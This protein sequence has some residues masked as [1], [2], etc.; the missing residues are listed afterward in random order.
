MSSSWK[1][2]LAIFLPLAAVV[3]A[4]ILLRNPGE[5]GAG[6]ADLRLEVIT[7]H[8]ETIRREIG[9]AFSTWYYEKYGKTVYVNWRTPGGTSE[10]KRVLDSS[11]QA[12]EADGREG[13]GVDLF[14]GGGEYD[15][16]QQAALGR[17]VPLRVFQTKPE[18]FSPNIIPE[19][20]SGEIYYSPNR[21]WVGV[22]LSSFGIVY[23]TDSLA[24]LDLPEPTRWDDL[25]DPRY[26]QSL[27]L[28]D[29]TKSGS[30]AKAF[31]M[32]IQEK[33]HHHLNSGI[34]REEALELGWTEGLQLIQRIAANSRYFADSASKVP[35][36]VAQGNAAAGMC[37]DFYGR[38][39]SEAVKKD[40]GS[41]RLKFVTPIGGTS[42]SADPVAILKGAPNHALA[43]EFVEFLLTK[44][45][46][47]LWNARV[48]SELGPTHRALRRL[49]IRRDLYQPPY[50]ETM[51]DADA[52][53]YEAASRFIY[54]GS[55]TG[56]LFSA[57]RVIV[58]VM[59]IDSHPEM[60]EA[61]EALSEANFPPQATAKFFEVDQVSYSS[62]LQN[63]KPLLKS[64]DKIEAVRLKS[65]LGNYFRNNYQEARDLAKEGR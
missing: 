2:Y 26:R 13:I 35:H 32:L 45:A 7:P 30:V 14:F 60:K 29:P 47:M 65:R 49:P 24:R 40:D 55:L 1:K 8:T 50:L 19:T 51:V 52:M 9:E 46:Q 22:C 23:N 21:D 27:A 42:I 53:P 54:D 36:D 59:C 20:M 58:R 5:V 4:P 12:A 31:E 43:Q 38:T 62:T 11:Y 41:S 28:A 17:F 16:S 25:G 64:K 57:M 44:E 10:I 18:L 6:S 56:S 15:F 61:W 34:P 33:I 63:I 39:F 48:G 3:A 37:I